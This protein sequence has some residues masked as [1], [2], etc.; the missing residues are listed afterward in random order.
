MLNINQSNELINNVVFADNIGYPL[1]DTDTLN[2]CGG[3]GAMMSFDYKGKIYPCIRY[4]ESSLGK[5]REPIVIG[6]I[7]TNDNHEKY[8]KNLEDL[9]KIT[10]QSQSTE[11][12]LTCPIAAGCAWCSGWNYQLYGTPNKRC[13][14]ICPMHKARVL[15]NVYYWNK[16][17]KIKN[18]DKVF[19]LNLPKEECLKFINEN[20]YNMLLELIQK[21]KDKINKIDN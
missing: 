20:E 6:S 3:T 4:M 12:C 11:E 15:A 1:E 21:Q 5:E 7:N 2:W 17:Y 16:L 10:R 19:E 8:L 13:T 18:Q 14:Y 9:K